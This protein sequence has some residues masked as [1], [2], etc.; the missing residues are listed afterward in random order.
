MKCWQNLK[1]YRKPETIL[2][3][4]KTTFLEEKFGDGKLRS[5]KC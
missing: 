1:S 3:V 4:K 5:A 2:E